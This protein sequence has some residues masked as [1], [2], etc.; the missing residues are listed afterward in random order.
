MS[1]LTCQE[2]ILEY[3]K[4]DFEEIMRMYNDSYDELYDYGLSFEY[5]TEDKEGFFKWLLSWG[6]PSSEFRFYVNPDYSLRR[7]V[8]V[9]MDWFD[10]ADYTVT[11]EEFDKLEAVFNECFRY[12]LPDK[13]LD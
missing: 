4:E 9:F 13:D 12:S 1:D 10:R 11:G 5:D 2:R 7:I 6:G 3:Y 8:Y